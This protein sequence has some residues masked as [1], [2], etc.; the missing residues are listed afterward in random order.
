MKKVLMYFLPE[1]KKIIDFMPNMLKSGPCFVVA[2]R[3]SFD[4][5]QSQFQHIT[6][7]MANMAKIN[8]TMELLLWKMQYLQ[9]QT[10]LEK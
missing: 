9:K 10:L 2:K 5:M 3:Y 1:N 4:Q 6:G 7:L 8:I